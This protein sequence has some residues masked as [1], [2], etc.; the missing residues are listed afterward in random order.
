MAKNSI[1]DEPGSAMP[2][3]EASRIDAGRTTS[4]PRPGTRGDGKDN[5]DALTLG[6]YLREMGSHPLIQSEQELELARQIDAARR[7]LTSLARKVPKTWRRH[8]SAEGPP[9]LGENWQLDRL[10]RFHDQLAAL[11]RSTEDPGLRKIAKQAQVAKGQLER[12]REALIVANLRLVV[13][14]AKGYAKRGLPFPDLIQEGNLGLLKAVERFEF[15][16]GNRFSTYAYWWIKQSIDRG[17]AEKGRAIRI[18]VHLLER[19]K[20]IG[21]AIGELRQ[22]LGRRPT[23]VEI[24]RRLEVPLAKIKDVLELVEDPLLLDDLTNADDKANPLE[25]VADRRAVARFERAEA[26]QFNERLHQSIGQLTERQQRIIRLRFGLDDDSPR[27]LE[28][29]GRLVGLSR[30]RVRQLEAV[31]LERLQRFE[32]LEELL[33]LKRGNRTT[34][35]PGRGGSMKAPSRRETPRPEAQPKS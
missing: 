31:S 25:N 29:V 4:H 32:A 21:R 9:K 22:L 35:R 28:E 5:V 30:E 2:Y 20:K 34:P 16:R 10:G 17:L 19:R 3:P 18:P 23:A 24:A 14:I 13:H 12:A 11:A 1:L 8:I 15:K 7:S 6:A 33:S 26:L 27:S